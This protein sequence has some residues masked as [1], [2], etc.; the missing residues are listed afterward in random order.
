V[1]VITILIYALLAAAP[2]QASTWADV[3]AAAAPAI[4]R[5]DALTD[6]EQDGGR[7]TGAVIRKAT[8]YVLT[9]AHCLPIGP[10]SI[11]VNDRPAAVVGYN[12]ILDLALLR[13][14]L[15][16]DVGEF[17]L[18]PAMPPA[19]TPIA[20]IG[21]AFGSHQ[22]AFQAGYV[23]V[24]HAADDAPMAWLNLETIPGD[25]GGP[26]LDEAGRLVAIVSGL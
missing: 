11:T 21:H 22:L 8:G 2:A 25:S 4:V 26:V 10:A 13:T 9:A 16:P 5:V 23:S 6:D 7:C 12:W 24:P 18:A 15:P 14:E 3:F 1:R 19:G 20:V 17:A